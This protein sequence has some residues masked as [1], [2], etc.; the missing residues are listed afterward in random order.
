MSAGRFCGE[1]CLRAGRMGCRNVLY[2]SAARA[3]AGVA[4]FLRLA[5]TARQCFAR[6]RCANARFS[7]Q[8]PS[9]WLRGAIVL[10]SR[11][12]VR[13]VKICGSR[14]PSCSPA[15]KREP[16]ALSGLNL[17]ELVLRMKQTPGKSR[18][19]HTQSGRTRTRLGAFAAALPIPGSSRRSYLSSPAFCAT[20]R[21]SA[22][23]ARH[24]CVSS[25]PSP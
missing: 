6:A 18:G 1:K 8:R 16:L 11:G 21:A 12:L 13:F 24:K 2:G 4:P 23:D 20:T 3:R 22:N 9:T 10:I 14:K 7:R 19:R 25:W 5:P 17:G 15:P